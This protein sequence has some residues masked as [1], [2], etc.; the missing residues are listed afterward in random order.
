[1]NTAF[2]NTFGQSWNIEAN[3]SANGGPSYFNVQIKSVEKDF[4]RV[5][6]A[7][8]GPVPE[9]DCS[10]P[11]TSNSPPDPIGTL[12]VGDPYITAQLID[13]ASNC[14]FST[15]FPYVCTWTCQQ[16]V[17]YQ[18]ESAL[19][20]GVSDA[21]AQL[22]GA[23]SLGSGSGIE[24]ET[25]TVG[26]AAL[27]RRVVNLAEAINDSDLINLEK[28]NNYS[29][30]S[31]EVETLAALRQQ[32]ADMN[33]EIDSINVAIDLIVN[34]DDDDDTYSD[35]DE[36]TCGSDPLDPTSVPTDTDSDGL[37]DNGV[38]DDDDGDGIK[39]EVDLFPLDPTEATD[40]DGDGI[41]DAAD[42]D[43]DNDGIIDSEEGSYDADGDGLSNDVDPDSDND[44]ISDKKECP[45]GSPCPDS[46]GDG[47]PDFLDA[48]DNSG[49][50]SLGL[51]A[52]LLL[53]LFS[54]GR[55]RL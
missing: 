14:D 24:V 2:G 34:L 42:T 55:R 38:D 46:D 1:M 7:I 10:I 43:D 35:I 27:L 29:V 11:G 13:S 36:N 53:V 15:P 23:V 32:V 49:G 26:K 54:L 6:Q 45:N 22:N 20:L 3:S 48:V 33:N 37:C 31:A 50:G 51:M 19:F 8:D 25:V 4:D 28:I 44:G 40:T 18:V 9:Y 12:E 16:S 39:D 52:L 17:D 21:S 47:T 5:V 41:G 30:V